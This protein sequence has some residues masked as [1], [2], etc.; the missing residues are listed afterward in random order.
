[1]RKF[2]PLFPDVGS[3]ILRPLGYAKYRL[4]TIKFVSTVSTTVSIDLVSC[5]KSLAI[6][7]HI[8]C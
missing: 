8:T 4:H 5:T 2:T 7:I 3:V 1:M 6:V